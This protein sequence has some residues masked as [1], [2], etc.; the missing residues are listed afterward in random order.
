MTDLLNIE[1]LYEILSCSGKAYVAFNAEGKVVQ[2]HRESGFFEGIQSVD[3]IS[4]LVHFQ[5]PVTLASL[6]CA[7][8]CQKNIVLHETVTGSE[9]SATYQRL[10]EDL[11]MLVCDFILNA[12]KLKE[13]RYEFFFRNSVAGI[14]RTKTSGEIVH[15]NDAYLAIFGFETTEDLKN[16][17]A[18]DFYLD[19]ADRARYL[20]ELRANKEVRNYVIRNRRKDGKIVHLLTNATLTVENGIEFIDGILVDV[21]ELKQKDLEIEEKNKRMFMLEQFLEKSSE[22]IQVCDKDGKFVYMNDVA[23][24]RLGIPEENY[25]DF[26]VFDIESYFKTIEQWNEEMVYLRKEGIRTLEGSNINVKTGKRIPV[27]IS[28]SYLEVDKEPYAIASIRDITERK[29]FERKLEEA[30][31]FLKVLN[32]AIDKGSL[33]TETD[34]FGNI[35][36]VNEKFC[37]VSKYSQEELIGKNHSIV[38]S[39]YHSKEFWKDFWETIRQNKI[40]SGE[41]R[42][43]A[44]DGEIYW[45]RSLIYPVMDDFGKVTS[46]LSVRQDITREKLHEEKLENTVRFQDLILGI[47]N[48]FVN[49]PLEHFE[50]SVNNSLHEIGNFVNCDRV[51]VFTYDH[52]SKTTS[53]TFEWCEEGIEPQIEFLQN[54]PFSEHDEWVQAHFKNEMVNIPE[55]NAMPD[56][57]TKELLVSQGI[58]SVLAIPMFLN[59]VCEGFIGF[60]AVK[61]QK[62]FDQKDV[63]ILK[64][65]AEMLVNIQGRIRSINEL[66]DAKNEIERINHNL[67]IEVFEKRRENSKL[68]NMLS[69]HEKLAMLGEIAAGVAHDLN[70]PLGSIKVGIESIRFT[71]ENLF[72]SVIQGC[73]SEQL[74][75][76]CERAQLIESD[77]IIGGLQVMKET[78]AMQD[79]ILEVGYTGKFDINQLSSAMVKARIQSSEEDLVN[80]ILSL[81][82]PIEYLNLMYHIQTV[83][84][85]V[86][87]IIAS[88]DKATSVVSNLRSYLQ[89]SASEERKKIELSKNIQTILKVFG[90]ELENKMN[91]NFKVPEV[92]IDGFENKLFQLWSNIIKNAVEAVE[93]KGTLEVLYEDKVEFHS[94]TIRNNGPVI[95]KEVLDNMFKKFYTTKQQQRG[96]G[97][98]LSIVRRIVN[99]HNGQIYVTSDNEWTAFEIL[100]PKLHQ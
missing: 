81:E 83:R 79:R 31:R 33:V 21:S 75:R 42:N 14:F 92:Y 40:W 76:A 30:N 34:L 8:P 98:G 28:V 16:H 25:T 63:I 50:E 68:T 7:D 32:V 20:D 15:V 45:V 1:R 96:T 62:H 55:V 44:K 48:R 100:L 84:S 87:T 5:A 65:F 12:N 9:I 94:I 29:N 60:D 39:G 35:T 19:A 6:F 88:G 3:K 46:Y 80:Y 17:M 22:A 77:L 49:I 10:N 58:Q 89:N 70:T 41:I 11:H 57:P 26:S 71:L 38:N 13:L 64:L 93:D 67:E 66:S 51:Y 47:S 90:Y 54:L 69:D 85:L 23:R 53:N 4:D 72:H 24:K 86:D 97:L 59:N 2:L 95:E 91:I 37:E 82:N 99:D 78:K 52:V 36:Y 61:T 43:R 73:T 18:T 27:D 74:N 56:T